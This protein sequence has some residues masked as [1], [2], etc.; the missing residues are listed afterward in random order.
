MILLIIVD[1]LLHMQQLR[2]TGWQYQREKRQLL[3]R[4]DFWFFSSN[5][6]IDFEMIDSSFYNGP[7]FISIIPFIRITLD[8]GKYS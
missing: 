4:Y 8:S 6:H 7:Y 3:W 2:L 1:N 5:T